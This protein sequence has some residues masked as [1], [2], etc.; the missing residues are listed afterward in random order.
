MN[1]RTRFCVCRYRIFAHSGAIDCSEMVESPVPKLIKHVFT[2]FTCSAKK[3]EIS[4]VHEFRIAILRWSNLGKYVN[5]LVL[6]FLHNSKRD[7]NSYENTRK[8][9]EGLKRTNVVNGV[10]F[11]VKYLRYDSG[12]EIRGCMQTAQRDAIAEIYTSRNKF[13]TGTFFPP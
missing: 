11:E 9:C 3:K 7:F 8:L 12:R 2:S 1:A 5:R 13:C 6:F 4:R 10:G